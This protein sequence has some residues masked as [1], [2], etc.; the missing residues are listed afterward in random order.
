VT[1]GLRATVVENGV[2]Q[3]YSARYYNPTTGRFLSRDPEDGYIGV[4]ATLHKYL[5]AGSNPVNMIDPRG[6]ADA[7]ET[8]GADAESIKLTENTTEE[9]KEVAFENKFTDVDDAMDQLESLEDAQ[10]SQ[11]PGYFPSSQKSLDALIN[12]AKTIKF[13]P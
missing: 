5:Y 7:G 9:I 2:G 3:T 8:A 1:L 11:D 12:I 4:P 6:R 10:S 13:L